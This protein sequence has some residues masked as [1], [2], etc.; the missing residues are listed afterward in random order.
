MS[1][2]QREAHKKEEAEARQREDVEEQ[3]KRQREEDERRRQGEQTVNL[4][5][6]HD[7]LMMMEG[8]HD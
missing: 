4:D 6:S 2:L 5:S 7:A 3:I 8:I 1:A